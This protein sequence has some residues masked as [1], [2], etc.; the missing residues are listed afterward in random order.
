MSTSAM[1]RIAVRVRSARA[2]RASDRSRSAFRGSLVRAN[3]GA[4]RNSA[5]GAGML[6]WSSGR[7]LS[8]AAVLVR[9]PHTGQVAW[10]PAQWPLPAWP[11]STAAAPMRRCS[12]WNVTKTPGAPS[13]P[14][15]RGHAARVRQA[16]TQHRAPLFPQDGMHCMI[17]SLAP[18]ARRKLGYK[19]ETNV[20]LQPLCEPASKSSR[21]SFRLFVAA[22]EPCA[23]LTGVACTRCES[24]GWWLQPLRQHLLAA[25]GE[26]AA[27][28][29]ELPAPTRVLLLSESGD[30]REAGAGGRGSTWR[31]AQPIHIQRRVL[32]LA[33]HSAW[34]ARTF[35]SRSDAWRLGAE[36]ELLQCCEVHTPSMATP[37]V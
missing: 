36:T 13:G 1:A 9:P 22:V 12:E 5:S 19:P 4:F 11:A 3:V 27:G 26:R 6:A 30:A 31:A 37:Q 24:G 21:T 17:M 20:L 25:A 35:T 18:V 8:I 10:P 32:L 34:R 16:R 14:G 28:N 15:R 7:R 33:P 2:G 29:R 23:T